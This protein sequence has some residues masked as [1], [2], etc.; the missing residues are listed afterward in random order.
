MATAHS[1]A[2]TPRRNPQSDRESRLSI[3]ILFP[4]CYTMN[5]HNLN[6][7]NDH[8]DL[9]LSK[10]IQKLS[11]ILANPPLPKTFAQV[12]TGSSKI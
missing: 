5:D 3:T 4:V 9:F 11:I 7:S 10:N 8:N 2:T 12:I 1:C 6:F